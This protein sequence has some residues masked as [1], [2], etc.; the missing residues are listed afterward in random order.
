LPAAPSCGVHAPFEAS[1]N[2]IGEIARRNVS[3]RAEFSFSKIA[4]ADWEK[5][6][7]MS[8]LGRNQTMSQS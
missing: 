4:L 5:T 2:F 6:C 3:F 1:P 8:R 7:L